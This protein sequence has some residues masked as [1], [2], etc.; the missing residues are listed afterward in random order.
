[1]RLLIVEDEDTE[2]Q[3]LRTE[4]SKAFPGLEVLTISTESSFRLELPKIA[5]APPDVIILDMLLRWS[6]SSDE[7]AEHDFLRAGLRCQELLASDP[8]TRSTPIVFYSVVPRADIAGLQLPSNV[9]YCQKTAEPF[10]V[11]RNVRS[12]LA[13]QGKRPVTDAVQTPRDGVFISYSHKDKRWLDELL[14][15]LTPYDKG[16]RLCLWSDRMLK[17]GEDWRQSI[18]QNLTRAKVAVLLVSRYFLDSKFIQENELPPLLDAAKHHGLRVFWIPVSASGYHK[19][20]IAGYQAA[21]D[22]TRPL[23][24]LGRADRGRELVRIADLLEEAI[25]NQ[26]SL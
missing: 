12:L 15:T 24:S 17:P 2:A 3:Y 9:F 7:T 25:S 22:P 8:R 18:T 6:D 26:R 19:T 16:G 23:D 14:V 11:I 10:D 1:M 4:L 13:A 20:Q 21:S 5:A